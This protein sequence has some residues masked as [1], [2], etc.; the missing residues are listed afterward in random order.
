TD[1]ADVRDHRVTESRLRLLEVRV[2]HR[3]ADLRSRRERA[4]LD[5]LRGDR[6]DR[7]RRLLQVLLAEPRGDDDFLE[8]RRPALLLSKRRLRYHS[9]GER[10]ER[11]DGGAFS[12]SMLHVG[13][14][15]LACGQMLL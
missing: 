4:R 5:L 3:I 12:D 2:R 1:A 6:R 10:A 13:L 8:V 11:T 7:N 15:L 9:G 14:P